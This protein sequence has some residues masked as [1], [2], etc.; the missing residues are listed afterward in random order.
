MGRESLVWSGPWAADERNIR[1]DKALQEAKR[2]SVCSRISSALVHR[3][4]GHHGCDMGHPRPCVHWP[5]LLTLSNVDG[6][7]DAGG[8]LVRG[9][10]VARLVPPGLCLRPEVAFSPCVPG[11]A[12]SW[13]L[14]SHQDTSF[15]FSSSFKAGAPNIFTL[16]SGLPQEVWGHS[17]ALNM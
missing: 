10:P 6:E 7:A 3:G 8:M 15:N 1:V 14:S 16:G 13:G 2:C 17:S 5:E 9:P 4:P 11:G 12:R